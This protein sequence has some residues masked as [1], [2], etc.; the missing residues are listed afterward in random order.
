MDDFPSFMAK[1]LGNQSIIEERIVINTYAQNAN[2]L[3]TKLSGLQVFTFIV[4]TAQRNQS[5]IKQRDC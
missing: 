1:L 4:I 2:F 5:T 3:L